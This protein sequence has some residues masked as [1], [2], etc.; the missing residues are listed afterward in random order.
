MLGCI[1]R[2]LQKAPN[3]IR[4]T[5]PPFTPTGDINDAIFI[6]H[7]SENDKPFE[8]IYEPFDHSPPDKYFSFIN[9]SSNS[10]FTN[11][12]SHDYYQK[13]IESTKP[14]DDMKTIIEDDE[15]VWD[16][17]SLFQVNN[18]DE[19]D[20]IDNE[21]KT[22]EE[23]RKLEELDNPNHIWKKPRCSKA[24]IEQKIRNILELKELCEKSM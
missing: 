6:I 16:T 11:E 24:F 3:V 10:Y 13:L 19:E 5:I 7:R 17:V 23:I 15:T 22:H 9:F 12:Q 4:E 1:K 14:I 2:W 18:E 8:R 20:D 21:L